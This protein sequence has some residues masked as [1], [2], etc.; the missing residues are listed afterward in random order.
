MRFALLSFILLL[1]SV[2]S[3]AE[4]LR[5]FFNKRSIDGDLSA[6]WDKPSINDDSIIKPLAKLNQNAVFEDQACGGGGG[7]GGSTLI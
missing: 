7:G 5:K 1:C 3:Y 4:F 2:L 6:D